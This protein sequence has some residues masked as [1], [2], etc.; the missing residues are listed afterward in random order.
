M[1]ISVFSSKIGRIS[2]GREYSAQALCLGENSS[3]M[4]VGANNPGLFVIGK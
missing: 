4:A 3:S 1:K 2:S